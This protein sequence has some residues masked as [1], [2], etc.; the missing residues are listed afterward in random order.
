MVSIMG[1]GIAL[2]PIMIPK[3]APGRASITII[4]P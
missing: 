4:K 1:Q 2:L 3:G